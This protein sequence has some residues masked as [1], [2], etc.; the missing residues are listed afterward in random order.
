MYKQDVIQFDLL[1]GSCA[2]CGGPVYFSRVIDWEGNRVNTLHCWNGHYESVE[3][4]HF[5]LP[6]GV[7]LTVEQ[8]QEILPFV[9]FVRT[10]DNNGGAGAG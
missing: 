10:S 1:H 5:E 3:I 6:S 7:E 2:I 9:A 8:I 4:E